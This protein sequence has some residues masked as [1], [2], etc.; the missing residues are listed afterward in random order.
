MNVISRKEKADLIKKE[1]IDLDADDI[2]VI[3]DILGR[4]INDLDYDCNTRKGKLL[5]IINN[6]HFVDEDNFTEIYQIV[7]QKVEL[8]RNE[9]NNKNDKLPDEDEK[10]VIK[11]MIK[12][13]SK[14]VKMKRVMLEI[15]NKI[16]VLMGENEIDDLC[17]FVNVRRD[18][19]IDD[20][21][22]KLINDNKDYIFENGF[23]KYQCQ[24][25]QTKVKTI[26]I[27]ILRG[28][29]KQIGYELYSKNHKRTINGVFESHTTYSIQERQ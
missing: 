12:R 3:F 5:Q 23:N 21:Y 20:K 29:L 11:K 19:L 9:K 2:D 14:N 13:E 1:I 16:L 25:Y 22:A 27:S 15:I 7:I 18:V 17:E 8:Q 24:I 4:D 10:K 28:M 26:H 6:L